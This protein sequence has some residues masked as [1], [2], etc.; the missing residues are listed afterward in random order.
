MTLISDIIIS[1]PTLPSR[2][3]SNQYK[4]FLFFDFFLTDN[5]DFYRELQKSVDFDSEIDL[6]CPQNLL[7]LGR[8][9]Y[10]KDWGTEISS[11]SRGAKN[12]CFGL[13][14]SERQNGWLIVQDLPIN[15]GVLACD[16]NSNSALNL[17]KK[18]SRDWFLT[19]DD[20]KLAYLDNKSLICE[21]VDISFIKTLILNYDSP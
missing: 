3:I 18:I 10:K 5:K 6:Y 8:I 11:V 14:I 17:F 21:S 20:F 15:F 16:E 1:T 2:F 12:N 19:V 7:P 13:I 9:P 4:K